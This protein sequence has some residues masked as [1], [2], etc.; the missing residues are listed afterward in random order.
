MLGAE[1]RITTLL[2]LSGA[3]AGLTYWL[4]AGRSAGSHP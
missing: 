1:V 2:F 3:A 4:V